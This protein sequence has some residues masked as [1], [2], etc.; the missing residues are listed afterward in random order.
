MGE[1]CGNN[2]LVQYLRGNLGLVDVI[3]HSTLRAYLSLGKRVG[4]KLRCCPPGNVVS[5]AKL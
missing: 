1:I 3:F 4:P 2:V 5:V